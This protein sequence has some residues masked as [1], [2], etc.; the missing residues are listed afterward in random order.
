MNLAAACARAEECRR[1]AGKV[2]HI[3]EAREY[4]EELAKKWDAAV[5]Q[6]SVLEIASVTREASPH[7]W[8][9]SKAA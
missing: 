9:P 4:W 8:T 1:I 6:T 7:G 5:L 2:A 3:P